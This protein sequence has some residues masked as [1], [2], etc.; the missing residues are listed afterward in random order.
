MEINA[1]STIHPTAVEIKTM[2]GATTLA[3]ARTIGTQLNKLSLCRFGDQVFKKGVKTQYRV[4]YIHHASVLKLNRVLFTVASDQIILCML[5][6][7][8]TPEDLEMYEKLL[9]PLRGTLKWIHG[10]ES[11]PINAF[12][13]GLKQKDIMLTYIAYV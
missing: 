2:S 13:D 7:K 4:Q 12:G 11:F 6:I 10:T 8:F 3:E 1:Y 5:F 9:D